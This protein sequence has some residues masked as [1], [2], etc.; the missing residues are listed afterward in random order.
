[1][2]PINWSGM[3][4]KN[5]SIPETSQLYCWSLSDYVFQ[6]L[7]RID[8]L[9]CLNGELTSLFVD[10]V[11]EASEDSIRLSV[12]SENGTGYGEEGTRSVF[13]VSK[14]LIVS[15]KLFSLTRSSLSH[16]QWVWNQIHKWKIGGKYTQMRLFCI[17]IFEETYIFEFE[18][19]KIV[20]RFCAENSHSSEGYNE[21]EDTSE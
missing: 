14:H 12:E 21:I 4:G 5:W 20:E 15:K 2:E 3:I 7:K 18:R 8:Q 10:S 19:V 17:T 13:G 9:I 1:M 11:V 16:S 6:W